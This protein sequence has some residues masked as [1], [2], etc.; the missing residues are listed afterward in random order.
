MLPQ[1]TIERLCKVY[2]ICGDLQDHRT[3][4]VS[5]GELATALGVSALVVRKDMSRVGD[6]SSAGMRYRVDK[7]RD[8]LAKRLGLGV[9]RRVCVVGLGRLGTALLEHPQFVQAGFRIVAG[10]DTNTNRV[11]ATRTE[12]PLYPASEIERVVRRELI[13][14]GVVTVPALSAQRCAEAL[15]AGGAT[16]ILNFSPTA[17]NA[18]GARTTVRNV[19]FTNELRVLAALTHVNEEGLQQS[20]MVRE[21]NGM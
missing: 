14:I 11:E 12:V 1:P 2:Q 10:F 15:V 16:S 18:G 9:E 21:S 17:I 6:V 13:E 19:D 4:A 7:L 8:Q 3:A 5:S 20:G